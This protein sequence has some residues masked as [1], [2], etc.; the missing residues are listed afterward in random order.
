M[1]R[2]LDDVDRSLI[3]LLQ[4]APRVSWTDAGRI[5]G[6]SATAVATR[7]KA[8]VDQGS[9]WISLAPNTTSPHHITAVVEL[10]CE[11]SSRARLAVELIE[12]P[13]V[14]SIEESSRGDDLLLTV[15]VADTGALI[16]FMLDEIPQRGGVAGV[17]PSV[18]VRTLATGSDWRLNALS[19]R[20]LALV[21][22]LESHVDGGGSAEPRDLAPLLEALAL[23][24]RAS[25]AD[26]ARET[27]L[28]PATVRRRMQ[29]LLAGDRVILRCDVA[30]ADL[31]LP[32]TSAYFA[33]VAPAD[34]PR[35]VAI[36]RTIPGLRLCL[37]VTGQH[38]MIFSVLNPSVAAVA[39]VQATLGK[40]LPWVRFT[41]SRL[42]LR[43]LKRMGWVLDADGRPT[44]RIVPPAVF[45][46]DPAVD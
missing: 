31:G 40:N 32:V 37:Q 9:A 4:L 12:D 20:Q 29:A 41:E 43:T 15:V 38:N 24:P 42:M 16:A 27:G 46:V 5:L 35:T 14:I 3:H 10:T 6:L 21:R 26:L 39:D 11:P 34:I 25:L 36:L 22:C 2:P 17:R 18:V 45:G 7:W 1:G 8:L 30:H 33:Q 23:D 28:T 19:E 13:R 44:G